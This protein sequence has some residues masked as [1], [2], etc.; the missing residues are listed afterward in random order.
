MACLE[1]V[2]MEEWK[3]ELTTVADE[4]SVHQHRAPRTRTEHGARSCAKRPN[5]QRSEI[6]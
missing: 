5:L 6:L 3:D 2:V 4:T 1:G